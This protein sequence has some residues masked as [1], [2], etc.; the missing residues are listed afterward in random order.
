MELI[1]LQFINFVLFLNIN[2]AF[3]IELK[4]IYNFINNFDEEK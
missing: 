4:K 1:N 2:S 3:D